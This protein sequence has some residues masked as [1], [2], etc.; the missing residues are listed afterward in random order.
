MRGAVL[1]ILL[2]APATAEVPLKPDV[3]NFV[4]GNILSIFYHELG[5]ALI[6]IEGVPIFGQEEDAADVFS[7]VL[8]ESLWDPERALD[9]AY[10][11]ALGFDAEARAS[12]GTEIAWW[13]VHGPDEQRFYNTVCLFY[14]ADPNNRGGFAEDM[15]LPSDRAEYC[16][17]EFDQAFEAWGSVINTVMDRGAG[18]TLQLGR[19]DEG[20]IGTILTEEVAA[21]NEILM[22]G[23]P[24]AIRVEPCDE[25]N[26]FYDPADTAITFC[27]EYEAALIQQ[28]QDIYE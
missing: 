16:P 13:D 20:R 21:L 17:D 7:V 28:G 6:D 8:T 11:Y 12:A 15:D 27:T 2:A 4:E 5:H 22:L 1:L 9:L 14:G 10:D 24:L 19:T 26:A 3:A 25:A 23:A 18:E